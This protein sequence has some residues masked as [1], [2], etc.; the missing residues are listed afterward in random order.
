[1]IREKARKAF[2]VKCIM[3]SLET[4]DYHHTTESLFS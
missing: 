4:E 3:K 1:M 2:N